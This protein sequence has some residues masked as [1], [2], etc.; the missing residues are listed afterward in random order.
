MAFVC[1]STS[2]TN[3]ERLIGDI[4]IGRLC[5][6]TLDGTNKHSAEEIYPCHFHCFSNR[7]HAGKNAYQKYN[8]VMVFDMGQIGNCPGCH[9]EGEGRTQESNKKKYNIYKYMI[10]CVLNRCSIV[11]CKS[12]Q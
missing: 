3:T 4:K 2:T 8:L 9:Q 10:N 6:Y 12:C 7:K 1:E 5:T 11:L